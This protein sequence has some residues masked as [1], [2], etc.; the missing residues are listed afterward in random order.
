MP[1]LEITQDSAISDQNYQYKFLDP[2]G[3]S[4]FESGIEHRLIVNEA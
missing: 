2:K 3:L 1:D 4:K